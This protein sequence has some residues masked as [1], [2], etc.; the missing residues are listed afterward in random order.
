MALSAVV[1]AG[2][3]VMPPALARLRANDRPGP[4]PAM[5]VPAAPPAGARSS[6]PKPTPPGG[7]LTPRPIHLDVNGFWSWALLDGK[8]GRISG[9]A[10]SAATS[11]AESMINVWIVADYLRGLAERQRTPTATRLAQASA[12]IRDSDDAAAQTLHLAAGGDAQI[13][14]MISICQLADTRIDGDW[15]RTRISARDAVRLGTCIADGRAAGPT[16]TQWVRTEMTKVRG[17]AGEQDQPYGGRWGITDGLPKDLA[18]GVGI[19]NGWGRSTADRLWHVNCLAVA[20]EWVLAVL[21]RYPVR[22]GLT[23]GAQACASAAAQ[24]AGTAPVA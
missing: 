3:L 7:T 22:E 6:S 14:R 20:D 17:G 24:L 11:P 12:A 5:S 19:K 10:N 21:L 9:S 1:L 18:K 16:W 4:S 8:T 15:A 2:A 13:Q 23:W